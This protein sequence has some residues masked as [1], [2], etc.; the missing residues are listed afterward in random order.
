MGKKVTKCCLKIRILN[1]INSIYLEYISLSGKIEFWKSFVCL[2]KV[3]NFSILKEF[4]DKIGG[5]R[6]NVIFWYCIIKFLSDL[7][8]CIFAPLDWESDYIH[9]KVLWLTRCLKFDLNFI[10]PS[11]KWIL[12][13]RF[14]GSLWILNE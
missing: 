5:Y 2:H 7:N 14:S 6:T 12:Y 11:I 9:D 3:N 1:C 13:N 8:M 10:S 4:S